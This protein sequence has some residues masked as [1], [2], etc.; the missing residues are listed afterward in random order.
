MKLLNRVDRKYIIPVSSLPAIIR[1]LNNNQY[2]I[3]EIDGHRAFSY[4]TTYFDTTD[5][6]FYKDHHNRLS[7]RMKVRT[8]T[9][10]ENNL[11]FFEIKM[12]SN[13]RTNKLRE[14]LS[15]PGADLS[16]IQS[17]KIKALY[18][19]ELAGALIGQT[20]FCASG[21]TLFGIP[22]SKRSL[23]RASAP[24]LYFLQNSEASAGFCYL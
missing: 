17:K 10:K 18:P 22:I 1:L 3:L 2:S 15:A 14:G 4:L 20:F 8:R 16:G 9:Y 11:H 6:Q 23:L 5:Y 24:V 12:K 13:I 7:G 19:K 21:L